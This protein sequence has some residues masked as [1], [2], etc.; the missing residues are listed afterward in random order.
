MKMAES[1]LSLYTILFNK[2]SYSFEL[3]TFNF[4][5]KHYT[6]TIIIYK[7]NNHIHYLYVY[8]QIQITVTSNWISYVQLLYIILYAKSN[9]VFLVNIKSLHKINTHTIKLFF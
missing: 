2:Q 9:G 6:E 4:F 8:V 3:K 7:N 5:A 1:H